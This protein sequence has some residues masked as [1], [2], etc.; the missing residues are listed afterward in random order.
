[1]I[2]MTFQNKLKAFSEGVAKIP[3]DVFHYR[4]SQLSPPYTVWQEDGADALS[5]DNHTAEQSPTGTLDYYTRQEFDPNV[6]VIQTIL[7]GLPVA[8]YLNPVQFEEDTGIIHYE[9]V[10]SWP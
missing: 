1:M 10:W 4:R 5:A 7:S 3:G 2:Y 6:D 9:W 8:W